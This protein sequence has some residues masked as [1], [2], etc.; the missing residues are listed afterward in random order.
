MAAKKLLVDILNWDDAKEAGTRCSYSWHLDCGNDGTL[1]LREMVTFALV[2][3]RCESADCVKACPQ[4]A[5]EKQP[6]G[7]LK[8]YNLRCI[9]CRAC[10]YACPFGTI[11]PQL[12]PFAASRCD[13]CTDRSGEGG[14]LCAQTSAGGVR[15]VEAAGS[16]G[17]D[18]HEV[19]KHLLVRCVPWVREEEGL[20][21]R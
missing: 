5:L 2:C 14:P 18:V 11:L 9:S 12:V 6:D 21:K 17:E 16:T 1:A 15:Y 20:K 4:D 7:I 8:R 19:G 10:A 13:Y 3:R